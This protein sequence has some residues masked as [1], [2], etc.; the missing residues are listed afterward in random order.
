M[1]YK[2]RVAV[3]AD[4]KKIRELFLE[5]LRT[6]YCTDDVEGYKEGELDRFW[7][8]NE[9][10]IYVAEDRDV[11]GF[12]SVEVHHEQEDYIYLD[13]FSVTEAYRDKGIGKELL[14]VA[15]SYAEQLDIHKVLLHVEKTNVAAMRLYERSG[16]SIDSDAGSRYLL[17]KV[18]EQGIM[19]DIDFEDMIK[20]QL[21]YDLNCKPDDFLR[22]ENVITSAI[23]HEKR[24]M[25]SDE[26]FFLQMATFGNNAVISADER[27]HPWLHEWIRGKKGFWLFE[28]QN[29]WELENKVREYG[30]KMAMTHHMFVPKPGM[31]NIKTDLKLKWLEQENLAAYYGKEEFSNALCDRFHPE[32]PDVLAITALDGEKIMG[33]AGCSADTAKLWQVGVDVLPQY[34]GRGIAKTL[35]SL[36]RDEAF[37]RGAV[38]YYG[39]SLSNIASWKTALAS[40]FIPSWIEVETRK[41]GDLR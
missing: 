25:F 20:E 16:Y 10:R 23:L 17:R 37:R 36:L 28:Q 8:G 38:P 35:V 14:K 7:S 29:F 26:P 3:P 13:D 12:L 21:S 11:V 31:M 41:E 33:M 27:L 40:G 19:N 4:E 9:S 1:N 22:E 30:Y 2:I 39:T 5:M 6:I 24:R 15:E 18:K 34:R 32:R